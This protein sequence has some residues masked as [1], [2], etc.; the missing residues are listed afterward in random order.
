MLPL[1]ISASCPLAKLG[2]PAERGPYRCDMYSC[3]PTCFALGIAFN[4][5]RNLVVKRPLVGHI[6]TVNDPVRLI[7]LNG[8]HWPWIHWPMRF[9]KTSWSLFVSPSAS[10]QR[11][12]QILTV[13]GD[14]IG[15]TLSTFAT[16]LPRWISME[17][18]NKTSATFRSSFWF[19]KQ[20]TG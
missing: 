1:G 12:Y 17:A 14:P 20:W 4:N 3:G 13:L 2:H 7:L 15:H 8:C 5:C 19:L 11:K 9:R 18:F 16:S 6:D 10:K